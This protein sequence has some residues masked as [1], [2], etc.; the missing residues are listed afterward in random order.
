MGNLSIHSDDRLN[1]HRDEYHL[2]T[3]ATGLLGAYMLRDLLRK[4]YRLVVLARG[5]RRESPKQRIESILA[6]WERATGERFLRPIVIEGNLVEQWWKPQLKWIAENCRS[7]INCA[8]SLTFHGSPDGEP[9]ATNIEGTRQVLALCRA[10]GIR[11]LHH[12]STAYVA[13]SYRE[14]FE[15]SMLNVGQELRNDYERSK[16]ESEQMVRNADFIDSLTVYRPSIIVGDSETAYTGTYHGFYAVLKLAHTLV[17]RLTLGATSGRRLLTALGMSGNEFKNFV[18]VDWVSAVFTYLFSNPKHHGKTYH[19]TAPEPTP[20]FDMVDTIQ[21]AVETFSLLAKENDALRADEDW[22][23][24]NYADQVRIYENYL[25]NDPNFD[26]R[27]TWEAAPH[28]PCP[29]VDKEMMLMLARFA[30]LNGF[31]KPAP[32]PILPRC[33]LHSHFERIGVVW[34]QSDDSEG[35]EDYGL[36]I[37]GPG[38]GEW[39]ICHRDGHYSLQVG[40]PAQHRRVLTLNIAEFH[41]HFLLEDLLTTRYLFQEVKSFFHQIVQQNIVKPSINVPPLVASSVPGHVAIDAF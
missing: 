14:L 20:I 26:V 23:S 10:A 17:N 13:G 2:L 39:L 25:N 4:G 5:T 30:I 38:G 36:R 15:E 16:F 11:E 8:A 22:F 7:V 37:I 19:L 18:P 28:L 34:G 40:I 32:K 3:G 33:D 27:N 9:W 12:F 31:G 29:R 1:N 6:R 35:T 41:K 21:D 24:R